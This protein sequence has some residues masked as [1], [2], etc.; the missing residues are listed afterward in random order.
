MV[1]LACQ[2]VPLNLKYSSFVENVLQ[3]GEYWPNY[4]LFVVFSGSD[5]TEPPCHPQ[6]A[7]LNASVTCRIRSC[8]PG[9]LRPAPVHPLAVIDLHPVTADVA[10][11]AMDR[12][13]FNHELMF[14]D[15]DPRLALG[16]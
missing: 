6:P 5:G 4:L 12:P 1:F 16:T 2:N 11:D 8:E 3:T 9:T 7:D 15:A 14:H 13:G 10:L